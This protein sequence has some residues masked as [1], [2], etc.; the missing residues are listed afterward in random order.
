VTERDHEKGIK[1]GG[2]GK[3][4]GGGNGLRKR[5]GPHEGAQQEGIANHCEVEGQKAGTG[6]MAPEGKGEKMRRSTDPRHGKYGKRKKEEKL[7]VS[8]LCRERHT[9]WGN[10]ER[11]GNGAKRN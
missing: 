2:D 10:Q 7:T 9:Q 3:R 11:K 8:N 4:A 5:K 6:R 1:K